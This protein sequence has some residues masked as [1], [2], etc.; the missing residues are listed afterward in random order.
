M[1]DSVTD[2]FMPHPLMAVHVNAVNKQL[3]Q[4]N[5]VTALD[6]GTCLV[7]HMTSDYQFQVLRIDHEGQ[8]VPP[9]HV[10][11]HYSVITGILHSQGVIY[12]IQ[13]DRII[14]KCLLDDLSRSVDTYN[15]DVSQ[16]E[17]NNGDIMDENTIILTDRDREEVFIYHIKDKC[18]DVKI[19]GLSEPVGV[20]CKREQH[21]LQFAVCEF[22]AGCISV[23]D[24]MFHKIKTIASK[25]KGNGQLSGPQ[26][27]IFSPWG[28]ILVADT[29]NNRISEFSEDGAFIK[30]L[31]TD[32][33]DIFESESISYNHPYLWV[34]GWGQLKAFKITGIAHKSSLGINLIYF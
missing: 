19:T 3:N 23:Y 7:A 29:N 4:V 30:H 17:L 27:A 15:L 2:P 14:T 11:K 28:S 10:C 20:S 32:Q 12:I 9:V 13:R 8:T 25:G 18:K 22:G 31:L 5:R 33:D 21:G 1:Y 26:C 24:E 6:D 34:A 16:Q